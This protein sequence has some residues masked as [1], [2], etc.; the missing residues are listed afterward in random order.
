M[1]V[2]LISGALA[3]LSLFAVQHW[4]VQ[5]LIETAEEYE[6]RAEEPHHSADNGWQPSSPFQRSLFTAIA[7]TLYGIGS[8]A[9]LFGL[10]ALTRAPLSLGKGALWG[11]AALACLVLAP[12]LGLPPVPPGAAVAGLAERQ[13]WWIATVLAT[14][15]GLWLLFRQRR[16]LLRIAG[17]IFALLPHIVGAPASVGHNLVP[18]DLIRQFAI[19]SVASQA[20]FWLILGAVGGLLHSRLAG[21]DPAAPST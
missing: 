5:P 19:A 10:A 3:G 9:I 17:I 7:A 6:A 4:T 1:A 20:V 2:A 14:A 12:S 11:L 18:D 16:R 21:P 15:T 13:V 8:S